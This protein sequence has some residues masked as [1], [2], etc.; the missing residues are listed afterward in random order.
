MPQAKPPRPSTQLV[1]VDGDDREHLRR[2]V[3]KLAASLGAEQWLGR[4]VGCVSTHHGCSAT[5]HPE[6]MEGRRL[7]VI[8]R[9]VAELHERLTWAA[10]RLADSNCRQINDTRGIYYTDEPLGLNGGVAFLF[11][12]EG[13]QYP[14]MLA[15]LLP[16]FPEV[17]EHFRRCDRVSIS[18]GGRERPLGESIFLPEGFSPEQREAAEQELA[19]LDNA[20]AGVLVA[21]WCLFRLLSRLG[22]KADAI[23]GHSSGEISALAAAGCIEAD[24]HL[25]AELFGLGGVLQR[26]EDRGHMADAALLAAGAGRSRVAEVIDRCGVDA[27]IA[28]DNC[29]HQTVVGGSLADVAA[30]EQELQAA[31][32]VCQRL[33]FHR[34]YHT[35]L[36]EAYLD[37]IARMFD[38]VKIRP[39]QVPIYSCATAARFPQDPAEIRRLAVAQWA[40]PVEFTGLIR[41]MFDDGVRLFV[42]VGPRGNLTSFVQDVLRGS[43]FLAVASDVPTRDGVEQ[44][45][46]LAGQLAVHRV[47]LELEHLF[48]GDD[49]SRL[50]PRDEGHLAERDAYQGP[51]REAVMARYFKTMHE[52]LAVQQDVHQRFFDAMRTSKPTPL[53][54]VVHIPGRTMIGQIFEHQPDRSLR[55]RRR[56]D[57]AEDL[58]AR[59]HTLGGRDASAVDAE[60][61]GLAVMPMALNLEM[62]AE[63]ASLLVPGKRVVGLRCV[64]LQRWIPLYEDPITLE[65]TAEVTA[66]GE[67]RLE[68]L[69]LGNAAFP[70]NAE[71]SAVEGTVVLADEYPTAPEAGDFPLTAEEPCRMG[72]DELYRTDCRMF[73]GPAFQAVVAIDRMGEEGIEGQLTTLSH[74]GLFASTEAPG[75]LLDPL[76]IDASTHILGTW[77]LSQPDRTGRVVFPYELGHVQFFAPPPPE[78]TRVTCRV[79][80]LRSSSRQVSHCI[81]LIGPDGRLFCR[82]DPAEYWRFYWPNACVDFF[83]RHDRYLIAGEWPEAFSDEETSACCMRIEPSGDIVQPVIR[84]ALARVALS[85]AEWQQFYHMK[86]LDRRRTE[87][88]FGRIAAKDAVRSLWQRTHGERPFPADIEIET[89]EHG[90][91]FAR[92]RF[93]TPHEMPAISITHSDGVIVAL[94]SFTPEVG[95]D[96]E[97]IRPRGRRFERLAFDPQERELLEVCDLGRDEAIARFWCAKEAA[98]KALGRGLIEG[99]KSLAVRRFDGEDGTAY[100]QLGAR[101]AELFPHLRSSLLIARTRREDDLATA[102]TYVRLEPPGQPST[103]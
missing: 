69:D 21:N 57:L 8:V 100:V 81:D 39:P 30:V 47:P 66:E 15:D 54:P 82:V 27:Q 90:R 35:R 42:E 31:G 7:A 74:A 3:E 29:P 70:G 58:Y 12:G 2:E 24:D 25:L 61:Y 91:P 76:L 53:Q 56:I 9:S 50:A 45:Q 40:S 28:M 48:A 11:P 44:F 52:F 73:H 18:A 20:A 75:L 98:A 103:R 85:P 88:L 68:I 41:R 4:D 89:D 32:V 92:A 38:T 17:A 51:Q 37:P 97:R 64:R 19:R 63:A 96:V 102:T 78:G 55:M 101:L 72:P 14:D 10:E 67:V 5:S 99:P 84:A 23:A 62:M 34:A 22:V 79:K 1:I 83:R 94:A 46:H 59:D 93:D 6:T 36:F 60:H 71:S 77:H 86:G 13:A 95:V 65:L 43:D 16:R 26:E 80:I 87:W 33:P 49:S